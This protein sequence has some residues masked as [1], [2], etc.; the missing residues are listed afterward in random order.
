MEDSMGTN[1]RETLSMVIDEVEAITKRLRSDV[2]K[3]AKESGIDRR[4]RTAA[5]QL[6]KQAARAAAQVERYAHQVRVDLEGMR[7]RATKRR[8]RKAA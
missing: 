8:A 7:K 4:M 2:R 1:V 6:Q 5:R 3:A